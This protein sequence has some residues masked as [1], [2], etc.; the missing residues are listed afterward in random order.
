[1]AAEA[2]SK[3]KTEDSFTFKAG[4]IQNYGHLLQRT[5][6]REGLSRCSSLRSLCIGKFHFLAVGCLN[7]DQENRRRW[8]GAW[9]HWRQRRGALCTT[10]HRASELRRCIKQTFVPDPL[11][12]G[13]FGRSVSV[14]GSY[15]SLVGGIDSCWGGLK[16]VR[17][18]M[19][20]TIYCVGILA[21]KLF[22][23]LSKWFVTITSL[24][25]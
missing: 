8:Q 13:Y 12:T 4:D 20:M 3:P 2:K 1:M 14:C 21:G 5:T 9:L 10:Q 11:S 22:E 6:Y 16:W 7:L 15:Q 23:A 18:T 25:E 19:R 24:K 17:L